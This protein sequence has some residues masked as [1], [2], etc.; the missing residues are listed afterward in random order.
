MFNLNN[1]YQSKPWRKL[2]ASLKIER[3][4][5]DGQVICEYCKKPILKKYDIIGHHVEH[6]TEEN[7][8]DYNISLNPENIQLVHHRCHNFIHE[9]R[10]SGRREVYLVYGSPLSGKSTYVRDVMNK[11]DMVVELDRIKICLSGMEGHPLVPKLNA[12]V[13]SVRDLL[14]DAVKTRLGKWDR[15]YIIGGY[16][17]QADR[18]RLCNELGAQEIFIECSKEECLERLGQNPNGRDQEKWREFVEDWFEEF[19][20]SE[21]T[22]P[23]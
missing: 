13:F 21:E 23:L 12:V 7:V 18:Q 11:G 10:W 2:V 9:K 20:P 6:L 14:F 8:N 3:A 17:R 4:N 1:F 15:A 22:P 5:E 19:V 16:P